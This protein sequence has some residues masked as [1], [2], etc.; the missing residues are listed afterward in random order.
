M[1]TEATLL[2]DLLG[3]LGLLACD[4]MPDREVLHM[5]RWQSPEAQYEHNQ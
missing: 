5:V 2:C 3:K 1:V 4:C